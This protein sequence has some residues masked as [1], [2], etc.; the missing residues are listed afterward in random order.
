MS[1]EIEL[2]EVDENGEVIVIGALDPVSGIVQEWCPPLN[3]EYADWSAKMAE[4]R[5]LLCRMTLSDMVDSLQHDK[6]TLQ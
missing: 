1:V 6:P 2:H 4:N 5:W 3:V